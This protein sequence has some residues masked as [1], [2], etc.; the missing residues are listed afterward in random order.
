[1]KT[2]K[3]LKSVITKG[4]K[5]SLSSFT[6]ACIKTIE[7]PPTI[8]KAMARINKARFLFVTHQSYFD[9]VF[10]KSLTKKRE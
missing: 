1:M 8:I 4:C 5:A 2:N 7:S 9:I 6:D 10:V 3:A